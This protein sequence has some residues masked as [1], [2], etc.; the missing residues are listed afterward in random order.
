MGTALVVA[1][2]CGALWAAC[3]VRKDLGW[4]RICFLTVFW[5]ILACE[6]G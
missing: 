2:S 3:V 5:P 4:V 6:K 1:Y